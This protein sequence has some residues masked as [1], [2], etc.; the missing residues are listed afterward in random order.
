MLRGAGLLD[1][2]HAAMDL[3][4]GRGD[5]DA[6]IG[7]PR[8]DDRD[9]EIDE[10]LLRRRASRRR[11]VAGAV[12]GAG[13]EICQGPHRLG[14]RAIGEQHAADVGMVDDRQSREPLAPIGLP[15]T[16]WRAK[17]RACW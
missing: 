9:E 2:P 7:R 3:D 16:R 8:L 11:A 12:D 13:G 17:S 15:W 4:A 5:L 10:A 6:E 14:L 1:E